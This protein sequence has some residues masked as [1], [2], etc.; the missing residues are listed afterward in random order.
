[1]RS[2]ESIEA[3]FRQL[4]L[5]TE[6]DRNQAL[7]VLS[8]VPTPEEPKAQLFIRISNTSVHVEEEPSAELD[9]NPHGD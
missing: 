9:S 1:M 6:E 8:N 4:R 2:I 5:S 3:V 7:Q